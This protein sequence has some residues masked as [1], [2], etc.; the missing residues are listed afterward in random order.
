[1]HID[2]DHIRGREHDPYR[3]RVVRDHP[4]TRLARATAVFREDIEM[5]HGDVIVLRPGEGEGGVRAIRAIRA[6]ATTVAVLA[7]QGWEGTNDK[8]VKDLS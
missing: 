3:G 7:K 8:P 5:E 2:R 1:M 4:R 6:P